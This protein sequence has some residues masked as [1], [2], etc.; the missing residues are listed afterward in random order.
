VAGIGAQLAAAID[1]PATARVTAA[2]YGADLARSF[3]PEA[4]AS[5]YLAR[6]RSRGDT[7]AE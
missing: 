7:G 1:D 2:R 6:Y 4:M 3:S 5:A